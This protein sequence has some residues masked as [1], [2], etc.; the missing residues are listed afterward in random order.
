[1]SL[2]VLRR[3]ELSVAYLQA[4]LT[5]ARKRL[6]PRT[7][8]Q[9][10]RRALA[11]S[12]GRARY[13]PERRARIA[14][15]VALPVQLGVVAATAWPDHR[16]E[17][18]VICAA[19]ALRV[20]YVSV[21]TPDVPNSFG[22]VANALEVMKAAHRFAAVREVTVDHRVH[23][24]N[25]P[26]GADAVVANDAEGNVLVQRAHFNRAMWD[27]ERAREFMQ[28]LGIE[29]GFMDDGPAKVELVENSIAH[30]ELSRIA[31]VKL[32]KPLPEG[33]WYVGSRL[34]ED[35]WTEREDFTG[36]SFAGGLK[37]EA[38]GE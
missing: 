14:S 7:W 20:I 21:I 26:E 31:G 23:P 12:G 1:M 3:R 33:S 6:P 5:E 34:P 24:P 17:A 25:W 22:D 35:L 32:A 29:R 37:R 27:E 18:Q 8:G 10:H 28:T 30:A 15:E 9:I 38:E 2:V 19:E 11:A 4:A 13:R 16:V 36:A